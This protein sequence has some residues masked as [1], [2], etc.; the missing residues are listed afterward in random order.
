MVLDADAYN[1]DAKKNITMK[2]D[3]ED[4]DWEEDAEVV[5]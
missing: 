2:E 4:V 3:K 1:V 5:A